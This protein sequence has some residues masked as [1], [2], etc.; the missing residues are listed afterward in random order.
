MRHFRHN[1]LALLVGVCLTGMGCGDDGGVAG[2]ADASVDAFTPSGPYSSVDDFS[3][4][5][6]TAPPNLDA[7]ELVGVWHL[8]MALP[9]FGEFATAMRVAE[10]QGA[11]AYDVRLFGNVLDQVSV[12]PTSIL[13][14]REWVGNQGNRVYALLL[15][16][17]NSDDSVSGFFATCR[18]EDCSEGAVDAYPVTE[19][20][21]PVVSNM[22]LVAHYDGGSATPWPTEEITANVRVKDDI[23]YVVRFGDGMRIVDVSTPSSPQ[24]LGHA[25]V[26]VEDAEIYNDVKIVEGIDG[27]TY[28]LV[29]SNVRGAVSID[30]SDPA[31]P[32]EVTTFPF[33][34][35]GEN[36]VNVHTIFIEG[37][38]AYLANNDS[39]GIEIF[40]VADPRAPVKLGSY[41]HPSV[42]LGAGFVHDLYVENQIAYLNY[43]GIGMVLLDAT[44]PSSPSVVGTFDSYERRTSHSNWVTSAGGRKISVHGD[45]DFDAHVRIVDVDPNSVA[46]L[47]EIGSFQTRR[48]VS[49]HNIMAVG[50]LAFVTYYQDGF[51]VLDL[52]DPTQPVEIAHY[53]TWPGPGGIGPDYGSNFYEGAIGVEY[54]EVS[55]LIY[56]VDTHRGLFILRLNQP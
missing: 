43:W 2:N 52:S 19:T 36:R 50:D 12:T 16:R 8:D 9:G 1:L 4:A 3:G 45:E 44:N 24:E 25:P 20:G 40:A 53:L 42:S 21:E 49:V 28:A 55:G 18:D 5:G 26:M 6:C 31:N 56:V 27:K 46:F 39:G 54:D 22:T 33:L 10:G 17:V 38:T 7:V 14:R 47:D 41:I 23:A 34:P 30:V 11:L 48:H 29:A 51:R 15:C 37:T 35:L 13:M 32:V